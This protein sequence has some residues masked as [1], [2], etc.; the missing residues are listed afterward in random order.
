MLA[1]ASSDNK[2]KIWDTEGGFCKGK[3]IIILGILQGHE[4]SVTCI[5]F[6]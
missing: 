1:S 4:H 2:I 6:S 3:F 5:I